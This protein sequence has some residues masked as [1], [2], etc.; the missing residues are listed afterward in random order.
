M[1]IYEAWEPVYDFKA[2]SSITMYI[3]VATKEDISTTQLCHG[4]EGNN[5]GRSQAHKR[6]YKCQRR[7]LDTSTWTPWHGTLTISLHHITTKKLA[8]FLT[9]F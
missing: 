5:A 9:R 7:H 1:V 3:Q 2:A 4:F 8:Y 6:K